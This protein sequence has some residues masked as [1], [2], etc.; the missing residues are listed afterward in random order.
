[1]VVE[2]I[3]LWV[4]RMCRANRAERFLVL[5]LTLVVGIFAFVEDVNGWRDERSHGGSK[6]RYSEKANLSLSEGL[7]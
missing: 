7:V 6:M 3:A 4:S 2:W 5:L 1:L